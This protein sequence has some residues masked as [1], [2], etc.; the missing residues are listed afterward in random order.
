MK[1]ILLSLTILF[2]LISC[3]KSNKIEEPNTLHVWTWN[4]VVPYVEQAAE[5]YKQ[6]HPELA[7]F[8]VVVTDYANTDV[9]SKMS[10][11]LVAGG[12]GLP[13]IIYVE[14]DRFQGFVESFPEGFADV[15][16]F[17]F[18]EELGNF[19][20]FKQDLVRSDD[21]ILGLPFDIG[22]T[23]YF[24]NSEIFENAGLDPQTIETWDDFLA[25]GIELKEK[26]GIDMLNNNVAEDDGLLRMMMQQLGVYYFDAQGNI[27]FNNPKVVQAVAKGKEFADAGIVTR[28]DWN[29]IITALQDGSLAG[30]PFGAWYIGTLE[31]AV[32]NA[33][34]KWQ[35]IELP[36]FTAGGNRASN[37]GG[38]NWV[39]IN[40]SQKKELAYNFLLNISTD[41][42][43]QD[44]MLDRGLY[45]SYL[46]VYETEKFNAPSAYFSNEAIWKN[47]SA[48]VP[49][50]P[51]VTYT[52]DYGKAKQI[53]ISSLPLVESENQDI[54]AT[55]NDA[56]NT[57]ANQTNRTINNY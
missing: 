7:D 28:L 43:M 35:A 26:T 49:N 39:I 31:S 33:P 38:S 27:D 17:G 20:Q 44:L 4:V 10:T 16:E 23:A 54:I 48:Q 37:L 24:Y 56:S 32:S 2:T 9:Y 53:V 18:N 14:D 1:K 34:G 47:L 51:S 8:K 36:A 41:L 42:D 29:G 11:G 46:P 6:N 45:P 21:K 15:S 40:N 19:S 5:Q 30:T 55:L 57:L 12:A 50:I 25:M 22:P 13:D 3:A 52:N